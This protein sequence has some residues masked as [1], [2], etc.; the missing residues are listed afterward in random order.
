MQPVMTPENFFIGPMTAHGVVKNRSGKVIRYFNAD[1]IGSLEDG[2]IT[3]EEDF[4]FNDGEKQRRVWVLTKKADGTYS[5]TA[6]DVVGEA[7]G[8]VA[9][10]SMFLKYVLRI[11]YGD[12]DIDVTLTTGCIL[13][14]RRFW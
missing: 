7:K 6:G 4:V 13:P 8:E 2:I 12:G 3:L 1:I 9:G 11:P 14:P 5:G 10:N